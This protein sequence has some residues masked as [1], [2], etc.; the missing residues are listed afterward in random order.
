MEKGKKDNKAKISNR[1]SNEIIINYLP[2][3][4]GAR[5]VGAR[6]FNDPAV[7]QN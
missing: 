5:R 6:I 3:P 1:I 7:G 2:N 4:H